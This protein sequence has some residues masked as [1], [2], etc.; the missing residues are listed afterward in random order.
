M[1][2]W[3]ESSNCTNYRLWKA[4]CYRL[5]SNISKWK[6]APSKDT[7]RA[8]DTKVV[9][10]LTTTY[11]QRRV[12]LYIKILQFHLAFI[13][14][15]SHIFIENGSHRHIHNKSHIL[16]MYYTVGIMIA[17]MTVV[18][19]STRNP[20]GGHSCSTMPQP[21][22]IPTAIAFSLQLCC[23]PPRK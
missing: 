23:I 19:E 6:W 5:L 8:V 7:Q 11:F 18:T 1:C 14:I 3:Y 12:F 10:A 17:W 22:V 20:A 21:L 15:S 2:R 9:T 16:Y 4:G 13:E